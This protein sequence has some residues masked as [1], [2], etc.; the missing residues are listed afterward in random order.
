MRSWALG[1]VGERTT[2]RRLNTLRRAGW[3]VLHSVQ[4]PSKSDID[5]LVI[6]PPG[7]FT[8]NSKFH[9]GKTIWYGDHA[10]TVNRAPTRHIVAGEHEARRTSRTLSDRCGFLV[11]VRP[12]IA[13]VGAARVSVKN[14]A[15][16]VLVVDGARVHAVLSGLTPVLSPERV[17]HIFSVARQRETWTGR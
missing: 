9:K 5:H 2:G 15:P 11:P 17:E 14:A 12:V 10:I 4:W 6:G 13:I 3:R 1:L 7:V 16:P 8:I